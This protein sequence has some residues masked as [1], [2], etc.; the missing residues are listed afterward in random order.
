MLARLH[1]QQL[2]RVVGATLEREVDEVRARVVAASS[3]ARPIRLTWWNYCVFQSDDG[4]TRECTG[5]ATG[6]GR[7]T[8]YLTV[9]PESDLCQVQ[10]TARIAGHAEGRVA[11]A[12]FGY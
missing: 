2:R 3:S 1:D 6:V 10:L 11:A 4:M 5:V 7:I 9:M 12:V 8:R